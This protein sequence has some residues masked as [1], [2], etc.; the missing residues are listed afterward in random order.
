MASVFK[1]TSICRPTLFNLLS[2]LIY[3]LHV[4]I[5]PRFFWRIRSGE[6]SLITFTSLWFSAKVTFSWIL[7]LFRVWCNFINTKFRSTISLA[8][9]GPLMVSLSWFYKLVQFSIKKWIGVIWYWGLRYASMYN[10]MSSF[11]YVSTY[12]HLFIW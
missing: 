8:S 9:A 3:T 5:F 2:L 4:K 1:H 11:L 10:L 12:D 7:W 6:K